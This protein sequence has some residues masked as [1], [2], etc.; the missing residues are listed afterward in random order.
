MAAA[1]LAWWLYRGF[2][3]RNEAKTWQVVIL[4]L[5]RW[6]CLVAIAMLLLVPFVKLLK[7]YT[8]KPI[9]AIGLDNSQSLKLIDTTQIADL[10]D[11][12]EKIVLNI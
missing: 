8:E 7:S 10:R 6:L 12:I 5:M 1:V 3:R 4:G 11:K 2:K 9:L